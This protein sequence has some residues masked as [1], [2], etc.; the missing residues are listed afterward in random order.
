MKMLTY[1]YRIGNGVRT[2]K[3]FVNVWKMRKIRIVLLR[4]KIS[5]STQS[6]RVPKKERRKRKLNF[7]EKLLN[8]PRHWKIVRRKARTTLLE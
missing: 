5:S 6:L 4:S 8:L 2:T 7:D 1:A 3:N